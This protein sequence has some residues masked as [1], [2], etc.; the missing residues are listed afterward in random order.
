M[1][2]VEFSGWRMAHLTA[3]GSPFHRQFNS[4]SSQLITFMAFSPLPIWSWTLTSSN[5]ISWHQC[6][7]H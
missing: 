5:C 4:S 1:A 2:L 7:H 3:D 6:A